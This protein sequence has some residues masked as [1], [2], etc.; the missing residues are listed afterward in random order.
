MED[1]IQPSLPKSWRRNVDISFFS[2]SEAVEEQASTNKS[3][4]KILAVKFGS[5]VFKIVTVAWDAVVRTHGPS[6]DPLALAVG[7]YVRR[8][9]VGWFGKELG[10]N[11]SP[12]H[13]YKVWTG[14]FFA[15]SKEFLKSV[16]QTKVEA[17]SV[18]RSCRTVGWVTCKGIVEILASCVEHVRRILSFSGTSRG[19]ATI[20]AWFGSCRT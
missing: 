2:S 13:W 6:A 3:S 12:K 18:R 14:D 20:I 11:S 8:T 19:G 7:R 4:V 5:I 10:G 15:W 17:S 16:F 9:V 1:K